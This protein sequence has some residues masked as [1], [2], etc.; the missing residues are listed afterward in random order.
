M[1]QLNSTGRLLEDLQ[2]AQN[3]RLSVRH[4]DPLSA[5]PDVATKPSDTEQSIANRLTETLKEITS[6]VCPG[7]VSEVE[8][9]RAAMGVGPVAMTTMVMDKKT[10]PDKKGGTQSIYFSLQTIINSHT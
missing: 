10:Q 4:G 7:A 3:S 2:E 8:G 9:L 6:Q 5:T 1:D